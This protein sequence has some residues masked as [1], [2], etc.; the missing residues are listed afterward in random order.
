[1]NKLPLEA[2]DWHTPR[3]HENP[4]SAPMSSQE[5]PIGENKH[6]LVTNCFQGLRLDCWMVWEVVTEGPD[7]IG[8]SH[9][10][11]VD[12]GFT[13]TDALIKARNYG[14]T[15]YRKDIALADAPF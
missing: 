11:Y 4:L 8:S 7:M 6:L 10:R 1:M 3:S 5:F 9:L 12:M 15:V 14:W 13:Q 2:Y